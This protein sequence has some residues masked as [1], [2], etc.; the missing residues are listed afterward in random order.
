LRTRDRAVT[1][2]DYEHLAREAAPEVARVR[3]ASADDTGVRVLIVP[4]VAPGD[5]GQIRFAQLVPDMDVLARIAGH[6]DTRR[7][8]GARVSVEP[9][10]YQGITVVARVRARPR[11]AAADLRN[12]CLTALY[13]Y[14]HP[15]VGGPDGDGWP[16]GRAVQVG[17]VYAVLHSL[18]GIGVIDDAR[19]Y[20]ADPVTGERGASTQRVDIDADALV[21]SYEHQVLVEEG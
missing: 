5:F 1:F 15:V 2:E 6:L 19:L 7:T 11:Y 14:F 13:T 4:S 16:F 3:A 18:A 21:F 12:D 20:A 8:I 17:D 9:P 10:R